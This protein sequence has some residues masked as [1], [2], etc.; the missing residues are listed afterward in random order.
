MVALALAG[1]LAAVVASCGGS[2]DDDAGAGSSQ[3]AVQPAIPTFE[4]G[5]SIAVKKGQRF[6]VSL[7]AT[8]STGY[9]WSAAS[10]PNVTYLASRQIAGASMPGASG[11]QRLTFRATSLGSSTLVLHYARPFEPN[12]P[13][14]ET[15]SFPVTVED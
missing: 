12:S 6:V 1:M 5:D 11:T 4:A 7:A 9:S 15:E 8:P 13:P 10:N 3:S 14:A 2:G